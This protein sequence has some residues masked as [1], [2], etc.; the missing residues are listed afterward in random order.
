LHRHR[1]FLDGR[2]IVILDRVAHFHC[3]LFEVLLHLG[4]G[5]LWN[6]P[7]RIS[8]GVASRFVEAFAVRADEAVQRVVQMTMRTCDIAGGGG[9]SRMLRGRCDRLRAISKRRGRD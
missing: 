8:T 7:A 4:V 9:Q 2:R 3:G 6:C 5:S 1:D